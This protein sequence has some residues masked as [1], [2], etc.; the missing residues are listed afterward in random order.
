MT[1][2]LKSVATENCGHDN[3]NWPAQPG[4]TCS[5]NNYDGGDDDEDDDD[6]D[7]DALVHVNN[8]QTLMIMITGGIMLSVQ[9]VFLS[10]PYKNPSID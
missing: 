7:D 1:L 2:I 10:I 5:G 8:D 4:E 6:N 9:D 3:F